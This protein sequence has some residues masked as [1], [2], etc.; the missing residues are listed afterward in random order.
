MPSI[1]HLAY[2]KVSVIRPL[3]PA[4]SYIWLPPTCHLITA[5]YTHLAPLTPVRKFHLPSWLIQP[6][7]FITSSSGAPFFRSA[8]L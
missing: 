6:D 1:A 2:F 4:N 8:N 7:P 5:L 3:M